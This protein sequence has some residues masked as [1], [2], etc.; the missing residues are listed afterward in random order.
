MRIYYD[1]AGQKVTLSTELG[2]GGEGSVFAVEGVSDS[3]GKIYHKPIPTDKAEKLQ[4]MAANRCQQLLKVAAWV[5]ETL[6]DRAGGRVVGFLMPAVRAKEVHELYSPKS[7][8]THFPEA[9]WRFL[10]HAATNLARAFNNVHEQGHVI[11]DVNH[12]NCVVLPDGTVK[13]IDC[14][15]YSIQVNGKIYPCEVGVTTH[16]PPEL[17]G[18][19][20]RGVTRHQEHDNFG[21]AVIIF[22]LLFLGRHPF[23][24]KPLGGVER[25]LEDCIREFRFAYGAGAKSRQ[26]EQPPGTLALEAVS[27]PVADLFERAFLKRNNRPTPREWIHELKNLS[28]NL[29]RCSKSSGH[30]YLKSLNSCPW[31]ELEK[32]TGLPLFPVNFQQQ[33]QNGNF[34]ITTIEQLLNSIQIPRNLPMKP[35]RV[36][37]PPPPDPDLVTHNKRSTLMIGGAI[38]LEVVLLIFLTIFAGAIGALVCGIA[39][40]IIFYIYN[41]K[42]NPEVKKD[43]ISKFEASQKN[44]LAL[45]KEW[46]QR[47]TADNL[48]NEAAA[49]RKKITEYKN[50]PQL[51]QQKLKKLE[52]QL[53][54][55]QLEEYLDG[56]RIER[57][58]I[59]GIGG[60]RLFTLES[61]GIET[62]AD[63][64]SHSIISLP[65]FGPTY[66]QKLLMWKEQLKARFVFNPNKGV[67]LQDKQKVEMEIATARLQLESTLQNQVA[68]L[69]AKSANIN[70]KNQYL[71]TKAKELAGI[72][73]QAQSNRNAVKDFTPGVAAVFV[74]ALVIPFGGFIVNNA[75]TRSM[76]IAD[77]K[78]NITPTPSPTFAEISNTNYANIAINS[79]NANISNVS[80]VNANTNQNATALLTLTDSEIAA[81]SEFERQAKADELYNQGVDA[82]KANSYSKAEKFYR[83]AIRY[84]DSKPDYYHELGYALY[85]LRKFKDSIA[86][87]QKSV[88]LGSKNEDSEKILGLNYIE[89]KD[90]SKAQEIYAGM[91]RRGDNS[92]LV[93]F[94]LG[95]AAKNNGSYQTAIAALRRAVQAQPNNAKAHFEL[96]ICYHKFG[97][98]NLAEEEYQILLDLD[99]KLADSLSREIYGQ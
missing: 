41:G 74:L 95:V 21:L 56:F 22:Q 58:N 48:S 40:A 67:S 43:I 57:A 49:I 4:W 99:P 79:V 35:Q 8:R 24:G 62:A 83:E 37:A 60:S 93:N 88:S 6:H 45:E 29:T 39:L 86:A 9:D 90:W 32:R 54:D 72:L 7:R 78:T 68:Q 12:G 16:I 59:K 77:S 80:N 27:L 17:Q 11:G 69:R 92:F 30:H 66:T 50:L 26:V 1:S 31:C 13:L 70:G 52:D 38:G 84:N 55:R 61:Y 71:A 89:L 25:T 28:E 91:N 73:A 51:R 75:S 20:L 97:I 85:R 33:G 10:I 44:W 76:Q 5:T 65:G 98:R 3:V 19:N 42:T 94:N 46:S 18:Q 2:K 34:N 81:L 96:G 53:Y 63:V 15:S 87:L 36:L 23:S 47:E 64:F 14:D 82:T